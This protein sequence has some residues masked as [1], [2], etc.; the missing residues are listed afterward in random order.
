MYPDRTA[1]HPRKFLM[2]LATCLLLGGCVSYEP[3]VLV[4]SIT[5]SAD[6]LSLVNETDNSTPSI[7]LGLETSLNES[8][9]LANV[10][11]LPGGAGTQHRRQWGGGFS[12]NSGRRYHTDGEWDGYRS[13]RCDPGFAKFRTG[14]SSR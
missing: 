6:E 2:T 14:T 10:E 11:I 13:P 1:L 5:L 4:P 12:R 8:D 7:D 9:S 3:A